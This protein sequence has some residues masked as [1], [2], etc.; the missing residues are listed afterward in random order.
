[1]NED[2]T[3]RQVFSYIIS[4]IKSFPFPLFIMVWIACIWSIDISLRPYLLKIIFNRLALE[5]QQNIFSY[6]TMPILLYLGSYLVLTTSFRLYGYF[7]EIKMIPR[8]RANIANNAL[9]LLIDKTHNFYQN[10]FS[11]S[12][13]NKINDLTRSVPEII[14]IIIDR[15]FSHALALII[16]I[17]T[18]WQVNIIF[19]FFMI[20]LTIAFITGSLLFSRHFIPLA[21]NW[22]Q[23][24]SI[25][26]GKLVDVLSNILSV[27]LFSAKTFEKQALNETFQGAVKA[28]QK[29]QWAYFWMWTCYG[30]AFFILQILNFYFLC[31]GRQEGW[32][33]LGDFALV[34]TINISIL[35]FLWRIAR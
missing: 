11:G 8:M 19:A 16:A 24:G 27:R 17:I 4:T 28:E 13:T 33:T 1:M 23:Y 20:I 25:I 10:N 7:V 6:L 32:I 12:L 14:Q 3:N 21:D 18:L 26:T 29:M 9:D 31:K 5:N 2:I 35:D 30:Y 34:L 22:S 15:F